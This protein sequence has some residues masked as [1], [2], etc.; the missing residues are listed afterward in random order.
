VTRFGRLVGYAIGW[1][2]AVIVLGHLVFWPYLERP[3]Q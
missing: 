2:F 3:A 1:L